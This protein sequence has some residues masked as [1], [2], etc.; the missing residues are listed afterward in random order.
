MLIARDM[1]SSIMT[2]HRLPFVC[3]VVP[4]LSARL[5]HFT[6]NNQVN[7]SQPLPYS[8][9]KKWKNLPDPKSKLKVAKQKHSI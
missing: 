6:S 2:L 7:D 3:L 1:P 5:F 8:S 4:L 9:T